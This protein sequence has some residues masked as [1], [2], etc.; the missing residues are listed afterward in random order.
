MCKHLIGAIHGERHDADIYNRYTHTIPMG[1]HC[2]LCNQHNGRLPA[3]T[4]HSHPQSINS[5]SVVCTAQQH[6]CCSRE[7]PATQ[8]PILYSCLLPVCS[9]RTATPTQQHPHRGGATSSKTLPAALS[10]PSIEH[11]HIRQKGLAGSSLEQQDN[12]DGDHRDTAVPS[13]ST[14]GPT[15]RPGLHRSRQGPAVPVVSIQ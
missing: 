8:L 6:A 10:A 14:L 2:R 3:N 5:G 7:A 9:G 15:P 4:N 1:Q 13:L 12:D 11:H